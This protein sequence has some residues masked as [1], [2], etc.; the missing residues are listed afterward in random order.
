M[1]DVIII[2][3]GI[4]GCSL[5]Y[6]LS[7]YQV[8]TVVL[9]KEN[10]VACGT[11]KANSAI[12]H[13]GYDPRPGTLMAKYNVEGNR[14]IEEIAKKLD[15]PYKKVGSFVLAFDDTDLATVGTLFDRGRQN[16]VPDLQILSAKETLAIEPNINPEI[17]GALY[18]PSAGIVSPWEMAIAMMD[19]AL[20]NG[21]SLYTDSQVTAIEK[22]PDGYEVICGDKRYQSRYVINAA[23]LY[24]DQI[25]NMVSAPA[26]TVTPN[27]GEYYLLDKNQGNVVS[28]VIFQCPSKVGKGVLVSPTVHGNLIVGPNAVDADEKDD[29]GTTR[30]GLDFVIKAASRSCDKVNYRQS[31]RNFAGNRALTEIDDFIIGEAQD[32][33]GF[34]DIAGIKSPGLT[35]APA[36]A[37]D[38]VSMLGAA[39]LSLVKKEEYIDRREK[40]TFRDLSPQERTELIKKDSRYGTIIC[41]CETVTE[42]EIVDAI[43][44]PTAP[45]SVDAIKRRCNAGMGRCQGGFCGPRV[46]EILCREL[47]LDPR[48]IPQDKDGSYIVMGE[49]KTRGGN[50]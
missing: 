7:K 38:M 18:A 49:T 30:T 17:K 45:R 14:L 42:G 39:G 11:T 16:G 35:S 40:V 8:Q 20:R 41:R 43:H 4:V 10:D 28:H 26:F 32:A 5:A 3:A 46:L 37:V 12:V 6:E 22:K 48:E 25:H 33:K 19:T 36:I 34:F 47:G 23:G 9:E 15:V 31:I 13:A 29:V 2:G 21:V 50:N 27:K 1:V 44:S 24:S